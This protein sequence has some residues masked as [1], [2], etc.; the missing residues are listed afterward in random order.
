M[1]HQLEKRQTYNLQFHSLITA[2]TSSNIEVPF[3]FLGKVAFRAMNHW[4]GFLAA[5]S[6][7]RVALLCH[8]GK[9]KTAIIAPKQQMSP[10][11]LSFSLNWTLKGWK[12]KSRLQPSV[13]QSSGF[14]ST[15]STLR[16]EK[17]AESKRSRSCECLKLQLSAVCVLKFPPQIHH[18]CVVSGVHFAGYRLLRIRALQGVWFPHVGRVCRH[19]L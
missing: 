17:T 8:H 15:N 16:F 19:N 2:L 4:I 6:C 12:C 14:S 1:L 9:W 13:L 11:G 10:W 5:S 3:C 18:D 7:T